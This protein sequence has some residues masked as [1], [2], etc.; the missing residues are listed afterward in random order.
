MLTVIATDSDNMVKPVSEKK[1]LCEVR[2]PN[3]VLHTEQDTTC[4]L[5]FNGDTIQADGKL[6]TLRWR[7][8]D[9]KRR[10]L[11]HLKHGAS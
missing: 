6:P 1:F 8:T 5:F 7:P 4:F 11:E 2:I 9:H 3:K 10:Q